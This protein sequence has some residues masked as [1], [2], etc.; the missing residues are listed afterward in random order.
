MTAL[1]LEN[2]APLAAIAGALAALDV[3]VSLGE[4]AVALR[5]VRPVD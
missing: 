1:A 4:L 5:Y 3:S 2:A